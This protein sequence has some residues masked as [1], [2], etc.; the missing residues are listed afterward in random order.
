MAGIV[1]GNP[2]RAADEL[3]HHV[4]ERLAAVRV[5]HR[6]ATSPGVCA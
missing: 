1:G 6:A 4:G 5:H 2:I 3:D